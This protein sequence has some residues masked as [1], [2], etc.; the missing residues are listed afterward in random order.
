MKKG[1]TL[2]EMAIVLVIIGI[3]ISAAIKS[4]E[5]IRDARSKKNVTEITKLADAQNRFYERTGR[6]AGDSD[7][8]GRID[9]SSV[10]SNSYP[11]EANVTTVTDMDYPFA[12]L[13][14]LGILSTEAN[15]AHAALTEGGP[16]YYSGVQT[17]DGLNQ[18]IMNMVVVRQV[19]CLT[20]F[21]MEMTID[22][23]KPD[24]A[25]SA[26]TGR[27]RGMDGTGVILTDADN[28][29]WT[30]TSAF[31]CGTDTS[32]LTNLVYILN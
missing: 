4:T 24:D 17:M 30:S 5:M 31:L 23:T 25:D 18:V 32:K 11:D 13:E 20:A 2:V 26:G 3:I 28:A 12:E 29:A 7:N 27:V 21:H 1:F 15:S 19:P 9:H 16:A 10:T 22:H 6:Y 8:D 14:N